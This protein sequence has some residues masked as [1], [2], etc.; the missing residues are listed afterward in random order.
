MDELKEKGEELRKNIEAVKD[1]NKKNPKDK[2]VMRW[3]E[4]FIEAQKLVVQNEIDEKL[5]GIN[6][7]FYSMEYS[8]IDNDLNDGES[9]DNIPLHVY[10]MKP[11]SCSPV[12]YTSLQR[13]KNVLNEK[14]KE[15]CKF[16]RQRVVV[17]MSHFASDKD[18]AEGKVSSLCFRLNI[19]PDQ[20][21][22]E[23]W[24]LPSHRP[25]SIPL[26]IL[27]HF[28][29]MTPCKKSQV[30]EMKKRP[31][32]E[33]EADPSFIS[34]GFAFDHLLGI[35]GTNSFVRFT[36]LSTIKRNIKKI[37]EMVV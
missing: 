20:T 28:G 5:A 29:C 32:E 35:D 18:F 11:I 16:M 23:K 12:S 9:K 22:I 31:Q 10:A 19:L 25:M 6:K 27:R 8:D 36:R 3:R 33:V 14:Q 24:I 1:Y 21:A 2:E 7:C 17:V 34:E 26:Y 4:E 13:S 15:F 30:F 37:Q